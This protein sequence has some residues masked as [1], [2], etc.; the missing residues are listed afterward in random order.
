MARTW[1]ALRPGPFGRR[2]DVPGAD[3]M[4]VW[5]D[6]TA[7]RDL[8]LSAE[9]LKAPGLW[10][11]LERGGRIVSE[12]HT[13]D[14]TADL[15][16]A[17]LAMPVRPQRMPPPVPAQGSFSAG[18]AARST[19]G[20]VLVGII[21]GGCPFAT[22]SIRDA[23]GRGTRVLALWDQDDAPAFPGGFE[24]GFRYGRAIG[25]RGLNELMAAARLP[26]GQ[27]D[28]EH[29]YRLAG[30]A[31]LRLRM[32]HGAAVMS[33]LFAA[34][35]Y[36]GTLQPRPGEPPVWDAGGTDAIDHADLV[37]VDLPR[38]AVQDST[39]AALARYVI[40][41]LRFILAHAVKGQRVVVTISNG[42]SRNTHDGGSLV[43]RALA[44]T[45]AQAEEDG[46]DLQ[47]VL[48][49]GN[50]NLEQRHAVLSS[51]RSH[52]VLFLPP[53]CEM[54]QYVTVRW[55]RGV[56]DV[57]LRVTAP[58]GQATVVRQGRARGLSAPGE[59]VCCG[60]VSP[61]PRQGEAAR[62]LL[63]FG[64]TASNDLRTPLAPGGRWKIELVMKKGRHLDEAVQFWV[65][66]NQRNPGALPRGRQADF[67]DWD[68]S[69]H[70]RAWLRYDEDDDALA[71]PVPNGIRRQGAVTGLATAAPASPRIHVVG[72]LYVAGRSGEP[73]PYSAAARGLPQW[74]A[75][76]DT[77]RALPGLSMRGNHSGEVLRMAGTSFAAPLVARALVNGVLPLRG[78]APPQHQRGQPPPGL[79]PRVGARQLTPA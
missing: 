13:A 42:T 77:S 6:A 68:R 40:D 9:E 16:A 8:G 35:L 78:K 24:P 60:V 64:P 26:S 67:V 66:R 63:A 69:H 73:S 39:S 10:C 48:P 61:P 21:D 57:H 49:V 27:V 79:S 36:G 56:N 12:R 43:E 45:A 54:P 11:V 58:G 28:E 15:S 7:Y 37:F 3:P 25:R 41:G 20:K 72:G 5:A 34:P 51:G 55:P 1:Q 44:A 76:G 4:W 46:I 62:T 65:S 70:P 29:C 32:G 38:A 47:I 53:G 14:S 18:K 2:A 31:H 17:E 59:E 33:Q 30:C 22:Q 75:P 52:L 71:A 50:G 19:K 74:S 23:S